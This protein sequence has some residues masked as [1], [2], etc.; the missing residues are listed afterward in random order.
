MDDGPG[1]ELQQ[2]GMPRKN[3]VGLIN[4]RERLSEIYGDNQFFG[5]ET[6][7]PHGLTVIIHIPLEIEQGKT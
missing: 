4:C 7:D 6:T 1:L 5:I 3:G 2:N